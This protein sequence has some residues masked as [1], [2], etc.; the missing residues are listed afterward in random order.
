MRCVYCDSEASDFTGLC[1][2]CGKF[3]PL[4]AVEGVRAPPKKATAIEAEGPSP[5]VKQPKKGSLATFESKASEG[6]GVGC[7]LLIVI[8]IPYFVIRA[9]TPTPPSPEQIRAEAAKAKAEAEQEEEGRRRGLHCLSPWDGSNPSLVQQVKYQLRDPDSFEHIDTRITPEVNG[10]HTIM[11]QY[12][13]RN[14]FG[15]MNVATAFGT[16]DH[17]TCQATLTDT[18]E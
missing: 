15:G 1:G 12:R 16:V 4:P 9:C 17:L 13:A 14:G 11:M 8:A 18:G 7:A 10:K 6:C 2:R 3:S 5:T